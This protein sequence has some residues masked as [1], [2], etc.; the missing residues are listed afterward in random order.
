MVQ[1]FA[2]TDIFNMYLD[3]I[4]LKP[5][6]STNGLVNNERN[7]IESSLK[8]LQGNGL[9]VRIMFNQNKYYYK[10][11]KERIESGL[12]GNTQ[13]VRTELT[14]YSVILDDNSCIVEICSGIENE[15]GVWQPFMSDWKKYFNQ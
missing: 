14:K 8:T 10:C 12:F 1:D 9:R 15:F 4:S 5:T 7:K 11:L 6:N 13:K 2:T 3:N